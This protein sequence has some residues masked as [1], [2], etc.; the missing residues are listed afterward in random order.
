MMEE[1]AFTNNQRECNSLSSKVE[2]TVASSKRMSASKKLW[3]NK[4]VLLFAFLSLVFT[5]W[6]AG[7][8]IFSPSTFMIGVGTSDGFQ[9]LSIVVNNLGI[10]NSGHLP[11]GTFWLFNFYGGSVATFYNVSNIPNIPHTSFLILNLILND[12]IFWLKVFVLA[13]LVVSQVLSFK[14]AAYYFK[15]TAIA[16]IFSVGYSFCTFYFSHI[17][18]GHI[19]FILAAALMPGVFLLFE[20]MFSFPNRKNMSYAT[21]SLISLFLGDLQVTIFAIFYILLRIVYQLIIN[22]SWVQRNAILK[23]IVECAILFSLF[24][25]PFLISFT[26]IQNTNALSVM[27][28]PEKY[29]S[30]PFLFFIRNSGSIPDGFISQITSLYLGVSL[31]AIALVPLFLHKTFRKTQL[32]TNLQNYFFHLLVLVFFFFIAIGTPLAELVTTLFV[33]V[34]SRTQIIVIFSICMCAGYGLLCLSEFLQNKFYWFKSTGKKTKFFNTL[35]IIAVATIVFAD[36]T[37]GVSPGISPLPELT[38]GHQ[39]IQNQSDDFRILKYPVVWGYTN[40]ES[41]LIN[42]EIV[43]ESVIALRSYP[44]A[45]ELYSTLNKKFDTLKAE[46]D[47]GNFTLLATICGVKYILI[48]TNFT[49]SSEYISYF[50]NASQFFATVHEDEHSI[51]YENLYFKGNVFAL[52]DNNQNLS[53]A[54]LTLENFSDLLLEER[55]D[56]KQ[57]F[58]SISVSG[59]FS[60]P[61]YVVFSQSYSPFWVRSDDSSTAF[62]KFLNVTAFRVERG[63]FNVNAVFSVATQTLNL[64]IVFFVALILLCMAVYAGSKGKKNLVSYTLCSLTVFGV[65]I[66]VL[67]L[68]GINVVPKSL[69][70][71]GVFSGI[72][73]TAILLFGVSITIASLTCL[74]WGKILGFI[75]FLF[76]KIVGNLN[77]LP[78]KSRKILFLLIACG[79]LTIVIFAFFFSASQTTVFQH[80]PIFTDDGNYMENQVLTGTQFSLNY[81]STILLLFVLCSFIA[82]GIFVGKQ[83]Y[84]E[85]KNGMLTTTLIELLGLSGL[86]LILIYA[87]YSGGLFCALALMNNQFLWFMSLMFSLL[88]IVNLLVLFGPVV[89][90]PVYVIRGKLITA[91]KV[92]SLFMKA[93]LIVSLTLIILFNLTSFLNGEVWLNDNI[94]GILLITLSLYTITVFSITSGKKLD[95]STETTQLQNFCDSKQEGIKHIHSGFLGGIIGIFIAG[96][97]MWAITTVAQNYFGLA[98][99]FCGALGGLGFGGMTIGNRKL[100]GIIGCCFGF[101]AILF[102]L[103]MVYNAQIITGYMIT[104][105]NVLMPTYLWNSFGSFMESQF[106][107]IS[108]LFQL[109]FGLFAAYL[110]ASNVSL[111]FKK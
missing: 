88:I 92:A 36:I 13:T 85:L 30:P 64:Y 66:T 12:P 5:L 62:M 3:E 103:I 15:K 4:Q 29:N 20:K 11:F 45:S 84:S 69:S 19:G 97:M 86:S 39:F 25:A 70:P 49:K 23:R 18:N 105:S 40:Y 91:E 6:Y 22:P 68:I 17:N 110:L 38:G 60:E 59:N 108:G 98:L 61:A 73:N 100:R 24:C 93:L 111:S 52:K 94:A 54:N 28:I 75:G 1:S 21:I 2:L 53:I 55:I 101:F 104:A 90:A 33:R 46:Q 106:L 56:Y 89:L 57:D 26:L 43:G 58:N 77:S 78:P 76:T 82:L 72:F 71:Y 95:I 83:F 42:H 81:N 27:S 16:W 80:Q 67:A 32:K 35:L 37:V 102:G 44:P 79:L 10:I 31:F 14:L 47:P 9:S 109:S 7:R 41:S 87:I 50:D 65:I 34:P 63:P 8:F 99:I 107:N 96:L 51:V 48:E 74:L